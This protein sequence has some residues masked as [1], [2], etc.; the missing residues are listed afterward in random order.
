MRRWIGLLA[1][2]AL[3]ALAACDSEKASDPAATATQ[4]ATA[5]PLPPTATAIP[6]TATSPP[7]DAPARSELAGPTATP[8][9]DYTPLEGHSL[10][11]SINCDGI[12]QALGKVIFRN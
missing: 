5:T 1:L 9:D 4:A 11:L 10:G 6:P 7:T 8:G 3:L 2:L 12:N